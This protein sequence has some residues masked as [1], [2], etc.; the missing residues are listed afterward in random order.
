ML[1]NIM[2]VELIVLTSYSTRI[3]K[4]HRCFVKCKNIDNR[5]ANNSYDCMNAMRQPGLRLP[6]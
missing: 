1:K 2:E 4:L 3:M 5:I 6:T